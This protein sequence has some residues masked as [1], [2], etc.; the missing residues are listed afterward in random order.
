MLCINAI[1]FQ[2]VED[3][4][5]EFKGT[6][7]ENLL[8]NIVFWRSKRLKPQIQEHLVV[9]GGQKED[10]TS[11]VEYYCFESQVWKYW[12]HIK[13]FKNGFRA[14]AW[15]NAIYYIGAGNV[16]E[17]APNPVIEITFY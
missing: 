12:K 16:T 9:I 15:N 6:S 13:Q 11:V 14:V 4:I 5:E 17:Q 10:N 3:L 1:Q 2:T 7:A 8:R